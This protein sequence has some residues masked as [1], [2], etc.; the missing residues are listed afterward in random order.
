M[1][2][3]DDNRPAQRVELS[4]LSVTADSPVMDAIQIP[5]AY[6]VTKECSYWTV[7][8]QSC[9]SH[10]PDTA[11]LTTRFQ[12]WAAHVRKMPAVAFHE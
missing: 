2:I 3:S 11:S 7:K 12:L 6:T 8:K 4:F 10:T 5:S 9:T 1:P